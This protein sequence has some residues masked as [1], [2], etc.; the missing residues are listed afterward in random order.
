M[1]S[2]K[3]AAKM[4]TSVVQPRFRPLDPVR[5]VPG[6]LVQVVPR[7]TRYSVLAPLVLQYGESRS[8]RPD[9]GC[10]LIRGNPG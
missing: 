7:D 1:V 5:V 2:E 10:T 3:I 6:T 8:A 4:D 9:Q